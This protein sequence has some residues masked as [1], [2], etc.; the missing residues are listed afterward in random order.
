MHTYSVTFCSLFGLENVLRWMALICQTILLIL[1]TLFFSKLF[2]EG[3]PSYDVRFVWAAVAYFVWVLLNNFSKLFLFLIARK[4]Q[5]FL[6]KPRTLHCISR[7][8]H[9]FQK[10][11]SLSKNERDYISTCLQRFL[12]LPVMISCFFIKW[13]EVLVCLVC[14]A[15]ISSLV[16]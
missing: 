16:G 8:L 1:R 3:H 11:P 14:S 12:L 15:R 9:N 4:I 13:K 10:Y 7:F 2:F 6:I 5:G